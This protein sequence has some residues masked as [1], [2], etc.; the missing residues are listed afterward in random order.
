MVVKRDLR[1]IIGKSRCRDVKKKRPNCV[2][3]V[4][5]TARAKHPIARQA[6][7]DWLLEQIMINAFH[8]AVTSKTRKQSSSSGSTSGGS[9]GNLDRVE[10]GSGASENL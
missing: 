3:N 8:N 7:N 10:G 2:S 9:A 6:E 5:Q 1:N 4:K